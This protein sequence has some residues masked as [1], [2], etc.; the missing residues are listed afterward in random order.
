MKNSLYYIGIDLG[1]QSSYFVIQNQTGTT[2][3]RLKVANHSSSIQEALKPFLDTPCQAVIEATSNYYWMYQQLHALGIKVK[4]AHPLKT[5][6]IA[7]AK[8]KNDRLDASMLARLLRGD[9]IPES[10]IPTE[11]IRFL[12]ELT[13]Q[14]IR[15]TQIRT[16]IKNQ[17]HAL[18]TK[19]N[20]Q[21]TEKHSDLFGLK[22]R[23]W[24]RTTT[25]PNEV[26]DFQKTQIID[27]IEY[28]NNLLQKTDWKIQK[29]LREFPEAEKIMTLP[30]IGKFAAAV[31]ISEIGDIHRFPS[32]KQLTGYAGLAPGLYESGQTS[33]SRAITHEGSKYL[34]WILC[35]AAHRHIRKPGLLREFYLRL[36]LK[37]G[38]SKAIVATARKFLTQI[39]HVLKLEMPVS[40]PGS[41]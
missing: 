7:S 11:K 1:K 27:Q 9:L 18:L 36:K 25:L 17:G 35:E 19:L 32:A 4:L 34:R 15:L 5:R 28:Y 14:H 6:A 20:L 16:R 31:I 13:R 39:Y 26:F 21:P 3:N 23:Q 38:H 2:Q 40:V 10:Y 24:L 8:I 22:G 37:K 30:G 12:R 33:H 29:M 41:I